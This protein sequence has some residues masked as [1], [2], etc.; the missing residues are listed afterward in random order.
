MSR[1]WVIWGSVVTFGLVVV[2]AWLWNRPGPKPLAPVQPTP[3]VST[4]SAPA[5]TSPAPPVQAAYEVPAGGAY[6][7]LSDPRW[8]WWNMMEK[9]DRSFEWKIPITFYG[10]VI[11][12]DNRP[13]SD[14]AVRYGWND[15]EGS[16]EQ[17]TTS[18]AN[19]LIRIENLRGK[20]LTVDVS[21]DGY[22][23]SKR[24]LHSFEYAAFFEGVYHRPDPENP[25]TFRLVKKLDPEPLLARHVSD[26]V[27]YDQASYYDFER[28]ALTSQPPA[29]AALKFTFERSESPQGQPFNWKWMVEAVNG[30]L[31]ETKDEFAQV[32]PEWG[33]E[34]S[35]EISQAADAQ[36]FRQNAQARFYVRT[37]A[38]RYARVD[39]E[40]AHPNSR[41]LGPRV[42]VGSFL[43]PSGSRNLE[44]DPS[45]QAYVP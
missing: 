23:A 36:P 21:K 2:V 28:G 17:Q 31:L 1:R 35:W 30:A 8:Q 27:L 19:G 39:L 6:E 25:V 40:V 9:V 14:A 42:S 10:K 4:S 34:P 45:K 7:G 12:Q 26:R 32:A 13:V 18:D 29:N 41:S 33:Y 3:A 44:H 20:R 24:G 38:D 43:N 37:A 22:H 5:Q 15:V 16:H 11:D